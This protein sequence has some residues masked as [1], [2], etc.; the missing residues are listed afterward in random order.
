[1][2]GYK[3]KSRKKFMT[4]DEKDAMI[5]KYQEQIDSHLLSIVDKVS[6]YFVDDIEKGIPIWESDVF[7]NSYRN[8]ESGTHYNFEN[9]IL[10]WDAAEKNNY[11]DS[12]F[13]T[14]KQGFDNG[15]SME[16]GTKG[17][18]IIQRYGMPMFPILKK[19]DNNQVIINPKTNKPI[20]EVDENGKTKYMYKRVSKLVKVFNILQFTG[21]IPERWNNLDEKITLEN[22]EELV[23]FKKELENSSQVKIHRTQ[24]EKNYYSPSKDIIML[25]NSNMFKNTLSEISVMTHEMAHSTGHGDRLDRESMRKYSQSDAFRGFEE[26]VANFSSRAITDKFGLSNNEFSEAYQNNHDAYDASWMKPVLKENPLL[27]FEAAKQAELAFK[28]LLKP[29]EVNLK[30]NNTLKDIYYKEDETKIKDFLKVKNTELKTNS[31]PKKTLK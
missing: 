10:L 13:I 31:K 23:E 27:I 2:A 4:K 24:N 16:K 20:K 18:Y 14:A 17:H 9:T 28:S 3:N 15:L 12:R 5:V 30:N 7:S 26:L 19:D 6:D 29:L 11:D 22:E 8:P 21:D 25:S 1:M